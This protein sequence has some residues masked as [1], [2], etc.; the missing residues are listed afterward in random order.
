MCT[1]TEFFYCPCF[2]LLAPGQVGNLEASFSTTGSA[3]D[4]TTR[5][6]TLEVNIV[7][8][9][10]PNQNGVIDSYEVTVVE[11]D[12]SSAVVYSNDSLLVANV[13]A[14]VMVLPYTNY[15]VSVRAST[16]AGQGDLDSVVVL[17]P[18]A[19][20]SVWSLCHASEGKKKTKN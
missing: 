12:D 18:E 14:S 4:S 10:P 9:E 17:S 2:S 13:T 11:T 19:G 7:W 15:T 20:K 6:Y 16:S 5:M 8:S 1:K 3:F